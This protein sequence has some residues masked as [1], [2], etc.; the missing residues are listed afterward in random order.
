MEA[1]RKKG[2]FKRSPNSPARNL[3]AAIEDLRAVDERIARKGF[4]LRKIQADYDTFFA[5]W[6]LSTS[7]SG[8]YGRIAALKQYGLIEER[9]KGRACL[10]KLAI[11]ILDLND[12]TPAPVRYNVLR[13]AALNP[14]IYHHL[15][16]ELGQNAYDQERLEEELLRLEFTPKAIPY[17]SRN[18]LETI[19]FA[20]LT[21]ASIQEQE[22]K[23]V[24]TQEDAQPESAKDEKPVRQRTLIAIEQATVSLTFSKGRTITVTL[25]DGD[26]LSDILFKILS[27][28][29]GSL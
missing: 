27:E 7:S 12:Q 6:E 10:T 1:T 13:K 17:V 8:G 20:K 24:I 23:M 2:P 21:D 18:Y 5:A 29:D 15:W 4:S 19:E 9:E 25:K 3:P 11:K 28:R 26:V 22:T 14:E 16:N